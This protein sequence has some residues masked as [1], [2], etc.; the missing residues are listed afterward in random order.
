MWGWQAQQMLQ[1]D[2]A[3]GGGEQVAAADDAGDVL[4]GVVHHHRKLVGVQ[5]VGALDDKV[6]DLAFEVLG[7]MALE[8]IVEFN[9]IIRNLIPSPL[10]G[11]G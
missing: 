6:A 4:E 8:G 1:V 9:G 10:Q 2:L 11:E 5:A 7:D 3:R